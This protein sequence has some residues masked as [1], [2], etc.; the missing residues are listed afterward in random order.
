MWFLK[1][2]CLSYLL[3]NEH[4]YNELSMALSSSFGRDSEGGLWT[5]NYLLAVVERTL[6]LR[7]A[8]PALVGDTISLLVSMVSGAVQVSTMF[9]STV[10]QHVLI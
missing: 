8:E 7:T 3:P 1:K 6:R 4:L 9:D 2:F 10:W 5:L